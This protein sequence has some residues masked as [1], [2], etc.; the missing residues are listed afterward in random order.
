VHQASSIQF[1]SSHGFDFQKWVTGGIPSLSLDDE[2]ACMADEAARADKR[3]QQQENNNEPSIA[4]SP[5][6]I[7][8][9]AGIR[10]KLVDFQASA[11]QTASVPDSAPASPLELEVG[12]GF[13]RRVVHSLIGREFPSLFVESTVASPRPKMIIR[14]V[15]PEEKAQKQ[16]AKLQ[17]EREAFQ[18][19]VHF[20]SPSE[21]FFFSSI[22]V[23]CSYSQ[24]RSPMHAV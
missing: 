9:E 11:T 6:D 17:S 2:A 8:W 4:V 16:V 7:A 10:T 3:A 18:S 19:K 23:F 13:Y 22:N 1:L 14:Y 21:V 20:I 24:H 15:T 12:N 5:R